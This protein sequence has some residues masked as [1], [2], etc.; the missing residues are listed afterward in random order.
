[1]FFMN[2][3]NSIFFETNSIFIKSLTSLPSNELNFVN[4]KRKLRTV[5]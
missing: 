1:M 2:L 4:N 5:T 3:T